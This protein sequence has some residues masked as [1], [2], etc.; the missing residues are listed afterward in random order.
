[1]QDKKDLQEFDLD[2]ILNEF[3]D[4]PE[5]AEDLGELSGDLAQLLGEWDLDKASETA[6]VKA[7][8]PVPM[9][10]LRM[11]ELISQLTSEESPAEEQPE[12]AA[13]S[14][15]ETLQPEA[16]AAEADHQEAP[17][18]TIRMNELI[19]QIMDQ[20][21]GSDAVP[22]D[23]TIR[24]D[25]VSDETAVHMDT[26]SDDATIRMDTVSDDATIRLDTV[27]DDATIRLD[28]VSDDA[29]I[30]LDTVSDEA[31]IRME[32]LFSEDSGEAEEEPAPNIIYNPRTRLRELKKKLVAGPEKRYYEL[33]EIGVGRLQV[34]ILLN[35]VIVVL[36]AVTTTMFSLNLIPENRLRFM[37]FSQILAMLLS[38]FLGCGQ[39]LDG[40]GDLLKGRFSINTMLSLTFAACCAD[41]V[42][43]LSELRIPCCAAFSLEITMA[44]WSKY[45]SHTTEMAQMDSL[46]KAVRLHAIVK[47]PDYFEGKAG[48]LRR[49]G[50]VEDFMDNYSKTS[51]PEIVQSVYCLLSLLVCIAIAVF[52]GMMH[53]VSMGIQILSTALLVAVPASFFVSL[54]RPASLLERRLHMVGSVLCGWQGVK[55]LC[56]KAAFPLR[57]EDLFPANTTKLNGVKF[58]GDRDPDDAVSY[59]TSLICAAG[60]GLVTIFEKML[61]SR[62]GVIHAVENFRDYGS[63]GIGGEICGEPVLLGTLDFLQDMGVEIPEGTMVSQAVYAAI[64]GQLCAVFA[65][66]YAKMRSAAAGIISLCGNR[67][68]TPVLTGIDF[69]LTDSL[70]RAKFNVNTR[71]I[72]FPDQAVRS[73]LSVYTDSYEF[74]A[75]AL[76]TRDDLASYAYVVSGARALRTSCRLGVAVHLVGGILGMLIMAVLA[77]LGTTELLTPTHILLYELVWM[78]PGLLITEWTR[79]V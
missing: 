26:V 29:T 45:Q 52:A 22:T 51:G 17:M 12:Q 27:S 62:N 46:R 58:Y 77:Y 49:D 56:G 19:S 53:G 68:I 11:N 31:T 66:S 42:F 57:D 37:I 16:D 36:C 5:A 30:R 14:T 55:K 48:I 18:D 47:E 38:A 3:H 54:T 71:R 25:P 50:E 7:E 33:S 76:A 78:I 63:G 4:A 1:M 43:C 64:D 61:E 44:L 60:G 70:L 8:A 9:D 65:I 35:L 73:D 79:T 15:E 13:A 24:I 69:M 39:M 20:Q 41:A 23:D 32:P 67:K 6:P 2:D 21:E 40:L 75:L 28:T 72:S 10:T 74:P 59:S 34:S